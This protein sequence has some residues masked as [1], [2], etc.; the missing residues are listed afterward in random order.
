M[1]HGIRRPE[2]SSLAEAIVYQQLNGK[3]A[4][5]IFKR[6]AALAGD[7]LTP[8][9]ILK[10]SDEQLRSVGLS[11]QKSAY[12]KDLAAKTS[13]RAS[14][15]FT[16][17]RF[18][19]RGSHR[20]SDSGQRHWRVDRAHVPDVL[21]APAE[22]SADRRLWRA[23]GGKEALQEAQSCRSR[24]T[25]KKSRG[26]GNPTAALPAG[27]CGAAWISKH[28]SRRRSRQSL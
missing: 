18:V 12:L 25:W 10:L 17:P 1:P 14:R 19:G 24:K 4:V 2:F 26:P 16:A 23:G 3:A 28:F 21:A 22:Y 7:P 11:K 5:T 13:C 9:G 20:A 15:F 6:F 8:E 27:T